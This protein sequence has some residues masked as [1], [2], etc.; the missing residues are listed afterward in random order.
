MNL[1]TWEDLTEM[2]DAT[3]D[4]YLREVLRKAEAAS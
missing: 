4:E 3:G 2:A 1:G